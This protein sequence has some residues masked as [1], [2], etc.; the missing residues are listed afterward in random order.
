MNQGSRS[1]RLTSTIEQAPTTSEGAH[2][3]VVPPSKIRQARA[4]DADRHARPFFADVLSTEKSDLSAMPHMRTCASEDKTF[5]A[6]CRPAWRG[7][8]PGKT[9]GATSCRTSVMFTFD[10]AGADRTASNAS[11]RPRIHGI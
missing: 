11:S 1:R 4:R 3:E 8:S 7:R 2:D 10:A 5:Q 9:I 6:I